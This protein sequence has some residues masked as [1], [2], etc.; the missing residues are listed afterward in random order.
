M[1]MLRTINKLSVNWMYLRR[2][3]FWKQRSFPLDPPI[4]TIMC[5]IR[6]IFLISI[7]AAT[8][9]YTTPPN[10]YTFASTLSFLRYFFFTLLIPLSLGPLVSVCR[11]SVSI[12]LTVTVRWIIQDGHIPRRGRQFLLVSHFREYVQKSWTR[13]RVYI[14]QGLL[15]ICGC[16][17]GYR[18][19]WTVY[20]GG[21][22]LILDQLNNYGSAC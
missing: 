15:W 21:S 7:L 22:P 10:T 14:L 16:V 12:N 17:R 18:V 3:T 6:K 5:A 9:A 4:K 20:Q 8:S 11:S 2:R 13:T 19:V 1:I